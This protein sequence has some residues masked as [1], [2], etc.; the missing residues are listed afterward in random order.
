MTA[1]KRIRE[2]VSE[3]SW[4][5]RDYVDFI[6]IL[7]KNKPEV[8]EEI[9]KVFKREEVKVINGI[10]KTSE[11]RRIWI[12]KLQL[13]EEKIRKII[14]EIM[15][16]KDVEDVKIGRRRVIEIPELN[17][18]IELKSIGGETTVIPEAILKLLRKAMQEIFENA[19]KALAYHLGKK[20]SKEILKYSSINGNGDE[21]VR[22]IKLLMEISKVMGVIEE[23]SIENN[24]K[25]QI[26]LKIKISEKQKEE[27]RLT[28]KYFVK[29]I[30]SGISTQHED[31]KS[32]YFYM[33][34]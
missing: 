4:G 13:P 27:E 7:T 12:Y 11:S 21:L 34:Y 19:N 18:F 2:E 16:I 23:Y 26:K 15:K 28:C 6:I 20:I 10:F 25:K 29:G 31:F 33:V 3:D 22:N 32:E 14:E 1:E 24:E 8:I 30:L 17:I 9:E 5:V